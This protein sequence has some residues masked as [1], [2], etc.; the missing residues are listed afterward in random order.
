MSH[1]N[2][3]AA[4]SRNPKRAASAANDKHGFTAEVTKNLGRCKIKMR[5]SRG[6]NTSTDEA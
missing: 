5:S 4:V 1:I 6:K 3:G 2:T